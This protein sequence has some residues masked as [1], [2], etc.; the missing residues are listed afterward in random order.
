MT[1]LY[2]VAQQRSEEILREVEP[3]RLEKSMLW[4]LER[5][6]SRLLKLLK[7]LKIPLL[8][9]ATSPVVWRKP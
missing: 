3:G 9:L 5:G 2:E 8:V 1:D 4:E 6:A 7:A